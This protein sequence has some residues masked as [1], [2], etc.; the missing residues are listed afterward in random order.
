MAKREVHE[1]PPKPESIFIEQQL[2]AGTLRSLP[3][4]G[5]FRKGSSGDQPLTP[6]SLKARPLPP[7]EMSNVS[8]SFRNFQK[9]A[10][11][12]DRTSAIESHPQTR[13]VSQR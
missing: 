3:L 12:S 4:E 13:Q 8:N 11:R 2:T 1:F 9:D 5:C 6:K 10:S 7:D